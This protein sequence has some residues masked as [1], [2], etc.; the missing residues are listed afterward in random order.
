MTSIEL[1]D[2]E[3]REAARKRLQDLCENPCSE[4]LIDG[5]LT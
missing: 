1:S 5:S 4:D 3:K 2:D